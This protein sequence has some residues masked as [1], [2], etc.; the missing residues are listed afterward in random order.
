MLT[1]CW[2]RLRRGSHASLCRVCCPDG[3]RNG[4]R[5]ERLKRELGN[6]SNASSE[7]EFYEA[8]GW[9]VGDEGDGVRQILRMGG[10]TALTARWA[11]MP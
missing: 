11:A 8:C 6:R 7:V 5:L 4:V 2:L 9:L 10:L 3:Q 1:W